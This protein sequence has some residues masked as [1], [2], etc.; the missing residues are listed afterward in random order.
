[1]GVA[2]GI[3]ADKYNNIYSAGSIMDTISYNPIVVI[4]NGGRLDSLNVKVK[5]N[6]LSQIITNSGT[7]ELDAKVYLE[8]ARQ[9]VIWSVNDSTIA[10]I[11]QDGIVTTLKNG[12]IWAKATSVIDAT[13]LDSLQ[14]EISNQTNSVNEIKEALSF[15]L[16]LSPTYQYLNLE[17]KKMYDNYL[18]QIFD[19][20][21]KEILNLEVKS[22]ASKNIQIDLNKFTSGEYILKVKSDLLTETVKFVKF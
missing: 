19:I 20:I 7:L 6:L 10:S 12:T 2:T 15:S 9:D 1:M 5:N 14:I 3:V 13:K 11:S 21:G 16:Y 18:I 22:N 8:S 4:W 17:F